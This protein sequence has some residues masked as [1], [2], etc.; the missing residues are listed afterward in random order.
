MAPDADLLLAVGQEGKGGIIYLALA[1]LVPA[2]V[3]YSLELE[4]TIPARSE[5]AE[6]PE[7][8][9]A[10]MIE[11][12]IPAAAAAGGEHLAGMGE[13]PGGLLNLLVVLA[14]KPLH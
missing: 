5:E 12:L 14:G 6:G 9:L 7:M 11:T 8:L 3:E 4:A 2:E 10:V 1:L 13:K